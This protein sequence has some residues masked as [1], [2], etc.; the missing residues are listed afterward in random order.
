MREEAYVIF[1]FLFYFYDDE[2][3]IYLFH[4]C[5]TWLHNSKTSL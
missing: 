1:I 2:V 4:N 5:M 3:W